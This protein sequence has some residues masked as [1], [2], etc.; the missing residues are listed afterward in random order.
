MKG[1]IFRVYATAACEACPA[2]SGC[3]GSK[4]G[5]WIWR[6][7]HQDFVDQHR[8]KMSLTGHEKMKRRKSMVEHPFGTMKRAMNAGYTLLKMKR[9]VKG[10]FGIIALTYNI[11]RVIRIN[12]GKDGGHISGNTSNTTLFQEF[13]A[14]TG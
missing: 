9:K 10:E 12:H 7:E 4:R 8:K 6:W 11:K 5:R 3:T 2:R 1:M 13:H 14:S